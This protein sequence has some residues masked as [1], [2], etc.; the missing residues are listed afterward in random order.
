MNSD[1]DHFAGFSKWLRW[2]SRIPDSAP[3]CCGVYA[4]RLPINFGRLKGDSDIV[5]VGCTKKATGTLANRLRKHTKSSGISTQLSK[6]SEWRSDLEIAWKTQASA[7][8]ASHA[9]RVLLEGYLQD[10]LE[11]P[12]LNRKFPG[13][14]FWA[15]IDA[16]L[17]LVPGVSKDKVIKTIQELERK[18]FKS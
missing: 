17:P 18:E 7:S 9:E 14:A 4:L 8:D 5:Y 11:L 12:P 15:A 16:L 2:N 10:H 6:I 13:A 1:S 3:N